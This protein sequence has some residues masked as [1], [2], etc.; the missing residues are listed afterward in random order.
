MN[1]IPKFMRSPTW[2]MTG[3]GITGS[4]IYMTYK[5][6]VDNLLLN[7]LVEESIHLLENNEEVIEMIGAPIVIDSSIRNRADIGTD[8]SN[9]SYRVSGPRGRLRVELATC[10][11]K[12][13]SLGPNLKGKKILEEKNF[14]SG[15]DHPIPNNINEFNYNEYYIPGL[16]IVKTEED[17][18]KEE[19]S[20]KIDP[21][22]YFWHIEY[23]FAEVEDGVRF[24]VA[25][26]PNNEKNEE[27]I[28]KR[29]TF[30]DLTK[31]YVDRRNS[32][33]DFRKAQTPE[34]Q[35]ELRK[36]RIKQMYKNIA[37]TR[38]YMLAGVFFFGMTAYIMFRKNKRISIC[39]SMI[40]E[41]AKM[42]IENNP[43]LAR[44]LGDKVLFPDMTLG[45]KI[46]DEADFKFLVLGDECYGEVRVV[47]TYD[48]AISKWNINDFNV[49]MFDQDGVRFEE[50][51]DFEY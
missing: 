8:I 50:E 22:S 16:E 29:E 43:K 4:L 18:F 24:M 47:G 23:L 17:L 28:L 26:I 14:K 34:E 3:A 1:F 15:E 12:H 20:G 7:P 2:A 40:H 21:Q 46:G 44:R 36:F 10:S 19:L 45:A 41:K 9:F 32:R 48:E 30:E 42:M 51:Y 38:F 6:R 35:E 27:P 5:R 39:N 25:P 13:D 31:E 49:E 11:R 37:Y 33:R